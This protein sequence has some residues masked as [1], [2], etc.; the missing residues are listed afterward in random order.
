MNLPGMLWGKVLRRPIPHGK[1]LRIDVEKAKKYPGVK[2]V[3]AAK[4]CRRA[5]TAMRSRTSIF[6]LS[7][8]FASSAN[9]T[10]FVLYQQ[11]KPN[12]VCHSL[13]FGSIDKNR[14]EW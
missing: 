4:T 6:L 5:A 8:K 3:I 1:L 2:A 9:P 10:R 12:F 11:M 14:I 13:E 7:T